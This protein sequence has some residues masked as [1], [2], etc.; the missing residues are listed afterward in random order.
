MKARLVILLLMSSVS[1]LAQN[2][3]DTSKIT[4][5][6]K[7]ELNLNNTP[8]YENNFITPF[9]G[10]DVFFS[11]KRIALFIVNKLQYSL[12][13]I[14]PKGY[15]LIE[16]FEPAISYK[17]EKNFLNIKYY[18]KDGDGFPVY[19]KS[20]GKCYITDKVEITGTS[21]VIMNLFVRYWQSP[22]KLGGSK[23]GEIAHYRL[24]GDYISLQRSSPHLCKIIITK[25]PNM[26]MEYY[27]L[28]K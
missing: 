1:M 25:N 2:K 14:I 16:K 12:V 23:L 26:D 7:L 21:D 15:I 22:M 13:D 11:S 10:L 27:K 8:P 9:Y 6:D 28:F 17:G 4:V 18:L 20:V 5:Y 24:M 19:S 3:M